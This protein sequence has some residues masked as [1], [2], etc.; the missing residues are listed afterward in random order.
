LDGLANWRACRERTGVVT[1][2]VGRTP[3]A[4]AASI[5]ICRDELGRMLTANHD[6]FGMA[7]SDAERVAGAL[8]D[9]IGANTP[10][11]TPHTLM[12]LLPNIAAARVASLFDFQGPN[13]VIDG[14]GRSVLDVLG[15]AE[16][17]LT[18]G[19]ADLMLACLLRLDTRDGEVVSGR[20]ARARRALALA[21]TTPAFARSRG[22]TIRAELTLGAGGADTILAHPSAAAARNPRE[23]AVS[24][25]PSLAGLNELAQA[26]DGAE[27]DATMLLWQPERR[28]VSGRMTRPIRSEVFDPHRA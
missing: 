28:A 8:H 6:E 12:G 27:R 7:R 5:R 2:L 16:R 21:L 23:V 24:S 11:V 25:S 19:T 14:G 22:W 26:L 15:G 20:P 4:A 10:A 18:S 13:L 1:G 3:R 17:W 9:A